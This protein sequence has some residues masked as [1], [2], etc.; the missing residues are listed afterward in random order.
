MLHLLLAL[1]SAAPAVP[2]AASAPVLPQL[3]AP[4]VIEA[5]GAP[6]AA[7]T[8][9]AAPFVIDWNGDGRQD[10]VVGEFGESGGLARVYLNVGED[11]AP[12]FDEFFHLQADGSDATV[13]SS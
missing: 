8:G 4:I 3:A 6:I 12:R 9:H 7:V 11:A 2:Q 13:P 10:L 1:Q 5:A